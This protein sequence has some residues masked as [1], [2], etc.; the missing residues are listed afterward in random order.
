MCKRCGY[1]FVK[2]NQRDKPVLKALCVIF[3]A[4]GVKHHRRIGEY[5]CRDASQIHRW[6]EEDYIGTWCSRYSDPKCTKE[7]I[8]SRLEKKLQDDVIAAEDTYGDLYI[9]LIVQR[10]K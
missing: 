3:R 2:E 4:L 5:L 10:R 7:W 9:A 6:M 8:I 1:H